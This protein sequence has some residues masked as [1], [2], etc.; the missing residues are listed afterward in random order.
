MKRKD[1]K[2]SAQTPSLFEQSYPHIAEWVMTHGWI[3]IGQLEGTPAFAMALDEGG[4]VWE[5]KRKYKTMDEAFQELE[6]GIA[7][8]IKEEWGEE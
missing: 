8:W 1:S 2:S 7:K 3:E 4:L 6:E 5:G